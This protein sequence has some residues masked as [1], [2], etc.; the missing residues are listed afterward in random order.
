MSR[1]AR[2]GWLASI[3]LLG[4]AVASVASAHDG[5]HDAA[6]SAAHREEPPQQ[7]AAS[8]PRPTNVRPTVPVRVGAGDHQ[9]DWLPDWEGYRAQGPIGNTHGGIAFDSKGM[10]YFNTDSER[11]VIAVDG[12]SKIAKAWGKELRGGLH[13][14]ALVKEADG[15]GGER[16]TLYLAH[17]SRHEVIQATLDG[18]VIRRIG[19][20]MEAGV[21]GKAEEFNPTSVAVAANGD[22]YVADG[23]GKS[24]VHKFTKDGKHVKSWG[25]HGDEPGKMK[26]PHGIALV[27]RGGKT[28]LMVA[29]RENH[30]LQEFDLDGNLLQVAPAKLR[31]PCSVA[32]RGDEL[33]V[34][35]LEGR[36]TILGKD[37]EVICHIG[38]NPD[39]GKRANNGVP[40]EQWELGAFVA[41]HYAAWDAEGNLY[42]LDWVS[43]GRVSKLKRV[44][45]S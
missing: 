14:M 38:D 23:Y 33:V 19:A 24:F 39:P 36:V 13:G 16:E 32:Q 1:L 27:T 7:G 40:M 3:G 22:L 9:Y 11:A 37:N 6:G 35:D 5:R 4:F 10:V 29:D 12:N 8:R 25:G 44:K 28:T 31:R 21:Y 18:E 41:P 20:P 15:K 45:G 17:T 43:S 26:T 34:A 2:T 30:R 42:V